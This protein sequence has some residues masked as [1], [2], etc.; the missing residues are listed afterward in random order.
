MSNKPQSEGKPV[1][2]KP[3]LVARGGREKACA[4]TEIAQEILARRLRKLPCGFR[5]I[6]ERTD[7]DMQK[8]VYRKRYEDFQPFLCQF[9]NFVKTAQVREL[10][11]Y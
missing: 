9:R 8:S 5:S 10:L 11:T 6:C 2:G 1:D 7:A 3:R 4:V